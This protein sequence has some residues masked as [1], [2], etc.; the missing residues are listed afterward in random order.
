MSTPHVGIDGIRVIDRQEVI[1]ML[2]KCICIRM[3]ASSRLLS[4][5]CRNLV[6]HLQIL[7]RISSKKVLRSAQFCSSE[8]SLRLLSRSILT[9]ARWIEGKEA[10]SFNVCQ[11]TVVRGTPYKESTNTLTK[12]RYVGRRVRNSATCG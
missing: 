9:M 2:V 4:E 11:D 10:A 6:R 7:S 5:L 1:V 8:D 12:N 3:R